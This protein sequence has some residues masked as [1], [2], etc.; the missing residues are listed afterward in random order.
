MGVCAVRA[1]DGGSI[2]KSM[3]MI[4][5]LGFG[6]K[7][8]SVLSLLSMSFNAVINNID[9]LFFHQYAFLVRNR[10][11]CDSK[12]SQSGGF[13]AYSVTDRVPHHSI[14]HPTNQTTNQQAKLQSSTKPTVEPESSRRS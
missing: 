14:I 2:T 9:N 11:R 13:K 12:S 5:C 4:W 7:H 10:V 3:C 6:R 8:F 1:R